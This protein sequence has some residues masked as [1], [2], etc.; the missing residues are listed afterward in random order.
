MHS[1]DKDWTLVRVVRLLPGFSTDQS[2]APEP[3]L[4]LLILPPRR[5]VQARQL[6]RGSTEVVLKVGSP[7]QM[8]KIIFEKNN[9]SDPNPD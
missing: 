6:P 2:R 7:E 4:L 3:P 9:F 8:Q 1:R 5:R